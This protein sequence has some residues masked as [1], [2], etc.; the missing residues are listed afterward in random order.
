[1]WVWVE[2]KEST[3]GGGS[4]QLWVISSP[5]AMSLEAMMLIWRVS[6]MGRVFA[7][8]MS[9]VSEPYS[10]EHRRQGLAGCYT[11]TLGYRRG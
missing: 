10:D 3:K 5:A 8:V 4:L 1:M 7:L 6:G 9:H 11:L 2:E